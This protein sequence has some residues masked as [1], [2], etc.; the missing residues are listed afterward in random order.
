MNVTNLNPFLTFAALGYGPA[1]LVPIVPPD[2]KISEGSSLFKRCGTEQDGRGKTPGVRGHSGAWHSFDW[3]PHEADMHDLERWSK[4]GA[5]VGI[6]TGDGLF[7]IDADTTDAEEARI[8]RDLVEQH[9]G[10]LPV[11]VGRYP[12]ALY[13][14]RV[15]GD[16]RYTRVD[17]G[18]RRQ[19]GTYEKRVEI[20]A[21]GKQFVAHGIHPAT[22]QPYHW[23]RD[24][25]PFAELPAFDPSTIDAMMEALRSAL[26]KA[27]DRLMREGGDPS[28]PINQDSLRG[29]LDTVRKAV[30]ATPNTSAEF[31]T[32]ESYRDFGYAIKAALPD[33]P[34]EAFELF[35][36]W[37][38][39]WQDGDNDPDV[40]A[41]DWARMKPPYRRGAGWLY[42]TA[43][44]L[45]PERFCAAE[46][47]F[48]DLGDED[49]NPFRA[50]DLNASREAQA[51]AVLA[52]NPTP[53]SFIDP[54]AL[55]RREWLYG[56][57][58]IRSFV[59]ATVAPSGVGKSSLEIVEA[60]AMASGKPLLGVEPRGRFRVW[61]WNGEDPMDELNRRVAAA[62]Q[63]HGLTREDIGDRL[64]VDSGRDV[65]II[66]A[67]ETR[68]GA[69]ISEP[70]ER[71]LMQ[72][73]SLNAFDVLQIDPFVSSHRVSENDNNAIDVVAKRWARI[74]DRG[75]VAVEL[76][77][78]VRKLNGA[79]VT[80]EDGRGASALI[81]AARPV[82]A[83]ARMTKAEGAKLGL[84][85]V[86][87]RLFRFA[88]G[89]NNLALPAD[90]SCE[91]FEL[92]SQAL[93]NGGGSGLDA[94]MHGD[95]VGVVRRFAM[96]EE[97]AL[98]AGDDRGAALRLLASGE[99]RKDV[100]A[101]DAWAGVA[102]GQAM[103]LDVADLADMTRAK[104]ILSGWI[105]DGTLREV[106]RKDEKR[107]PRTYIEVAATPDFAD[108]VSENTAA[109]IFA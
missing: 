96:P 81:A 17:F 76:V 38:D 3:V 34:D 5:G 10:R 84:E 15:T 52:I 59:S 102:I 25:V 70:V 48:Q 91:W 58:Y 18:N 40:V 75:R 24:I 98:L 39:R 55:P 103:R 108:N 43:E 28:R 61:L 79:E 30:E 21:A 11:R 95:H 107:R 106:T 86:A 105:K 71:G 67:T 83:I 80:V 57:H 44:R 73:I 50:A 8:I 19:N 65:E 1:R 42:E 63:L 13:L 41:A 89:K 32:R 33:N 7:A 68:D 51:E 54:S 14:C 26:P 12:K 31:G 29:Q 36:A 82:R 56:T 104:A 53:Y 99:W 47:W 85:A 90:D 9:L 37:C 2:A 78:H 16:Y 69:K 35:A 87:R 74:A 109:D 97:S 92:A 23:P 45:A 64:F 49:D 77:H 4:M 20:L 46:Q 6:K 66:L 93:G 22:K 60:L 62:M 101:G 88:D 100:R 27:A 94:I 72:A